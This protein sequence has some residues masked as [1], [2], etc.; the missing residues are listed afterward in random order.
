MIELNITRYLLDLGVFEELADSLDILQAN[1]PY[2]PSEERK[3]KTKGYSA[4]TRSINA[5]KLRN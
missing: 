1:T 3:E 4:I 5:L 2:I